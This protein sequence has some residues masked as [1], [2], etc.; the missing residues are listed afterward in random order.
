[1]TSK[2]DER[3]IQA[4]PE[5]RALRPGRHRAQVAGVLGRAPDLPRRAPPRA[6]PRSYVL[7]MF[8]YPSGSGLHVGHPEGYTATDIVARYSRMRGID[9]LH[10]MGWD[11]FGLPAEQH[12]IATGHAPARR[13]R[14][15]TSPPSSAS[16][17]ALGFSYDWSREIDT[18][19]PGY[20]RWT[21]WI[22]LQLFKSGLAYQARGPGQLVPRARD[23]AR[24]RGGHRRQER[25]R[26]PPG[27]A[28]AAAAVDAQDHRVRRPPRRRPRGARLAR[29]RR[30]SSTTGSGGARARRSTSPVAGHAG[31]DDPT[32]FT[33]RADTLAGRDLR[34]PRAGAPA[35]RDA[36]D[37]RRSARRSRAYVAAAAQQERHRPHRRH[38][39][40]RPAS[41]LGALA[42]RTR[43]TATRLP[44]W[45][46]D[47][48]IGTYGTGAVM[49]VPA[50]DERD[51][52]FAEDL[53][54]PDRA[55]RRAGRR[56]RAS[57]CRPRRSPT[58]ASRGGS[59]RHVDVATAR[60]SAEAR[61]PIDGVARRARAR[62]S[63]QGHLPPARLG[64]LA[65]ALL[66]RADPHL[67]PRRDGG[68]PA[69]AGAR[70][71]DPLRPAHRRRRVA[72]CRCASRTS[73]TS[74][75]ATTRPGRWR[76]PSTGASSRRT[77]AWFA[78]ETNTMPQWAGSRLQHSGTLVTHIAKFID[79][80]SFP[81]R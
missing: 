6:S 44:I 73:R 25:A 35:R 57:T 36:R 17:R 41:P 43:S 20:V 78:R 39:R 9:V 13:R 75:R 37:R 79:S 1:M 61:A 67:L 31:D 2:S 47:Y 12:A 10:P 42:R 26:R 23:G 60:P 32:V 50:H 59:E 52:A 38:A 69:R 40:R 14:R 48:V 29:A 8:P 22:F 11:A 34:R 80:L 53:R 65:A 77:D 21:Q 15:R 76:A 66:G 7:D 16:S 49:A 3:R 70:V 51:H 56:R 68:R 45:V 55:G 18:T 28:P 72:S 19:D 5:R 62:A 33:T 27:R 64:L 30:P 54:A 4:P 74:A 81:H 58:T 71:H 46:A 24:E 63:A